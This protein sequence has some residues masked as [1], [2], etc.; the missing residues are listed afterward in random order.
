M[1]GDSE[2]VEEQGVGELVR[3]SIIA[4]V[5]VGIIVSLVGFYIVTSASLIPY[6]CMSDSDCFTT[7]CSG[8][9]CSSE[10]VFSVCIYLPEF[11]CNQY[12]NC[13]CVG[14]ICSWTNTTEYESCIETL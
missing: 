4:V 7:G 6:G 8:E 12:R 9:I 14:G 5:I 10:D 3:V 1:E 2:G 11:G 13:R